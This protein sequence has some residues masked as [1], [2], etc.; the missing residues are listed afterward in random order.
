MVGSGGRQR[1]S[2]LSE[3]SGPG[4]AALPWGSALRPWVQ[5]PSGYL[6]LS[7]YSLL[8]WRGCCWSLGLEEGPGACPWESRRALFSVLQIKIHRFCKLP[9]FAVFKAS[10]TRVT[11]AICY[12][13]NCGPSKIHMLSPNPQCL[14]MWLCL[15]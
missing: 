8:A 11:D 6:S 2:T 14:R 5:G 13:L 3:D 9:L 1:T 10:F 12:G 7:L 4:A 15:R